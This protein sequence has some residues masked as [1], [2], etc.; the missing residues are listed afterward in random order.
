M[1]QAFSRNS[2]LRRNLSFSEDYWIN[3]FIFYFFYVLEILQKILDKAEGMNL[4]QKSSYAG[5][6]EGK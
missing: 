6:Q 5:F 4:S 2:G 3:I 1:V